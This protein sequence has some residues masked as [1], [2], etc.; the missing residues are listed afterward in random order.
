MEVSAI[1]YIYG[2]IDPNI[3]QLR[4]VGKSVNPKIRLRKHISERWKSDSH[5]NRWVRKLLG[6]DIK[7]RLIVIDV[8]PKLEWQFWEIFYIA[9]F[10]GLG[11]NLT[12][13]TKGGDQP[14]STK[15]RKHTEESKRKMSEIKKGKP[16]PWLH[17][18]E[19]RSV[20]HRNRLS[21]SCRGRVSEKKGKT[22]EDIYGEDGATVIRKKLTDTHIGVY[23]G[24]NHPMYGKHHSEET[25]LKI[26]KAS[27]GER[28]NRCKPIL[29]FNKYG[30]LIKEWKSITLATEE[31]KISNISACCRGKLKTVGGYKWEYKN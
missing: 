15:G 19:E 6:E 18:G 8:V 27:K 17:N 31:L 5:K 4:Y 13:G 7:P 10:K 26:S 2:L 24:K 22:Y 29:Q 12:N 30:E 9:Y 28:L 14:P 20:E 21:E 16:I 11:I 1:V 23:S 3:E 25:K